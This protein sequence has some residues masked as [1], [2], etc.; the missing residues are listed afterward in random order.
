MI[1]QDTMYIKDIASKS[2]SAL[3]TELSIDM[4][5]Y[6]FCY[7]I[8]SCMHILQSNNNLTLVEIPPFVLFCFTY[9]FHDVYGFCLRLLILY[10]NNYYIDHNAFT[11]R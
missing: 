8:A 5:P 1:V 7:T 9:Q 4:L 10:N 6:Q 3:V 2:A 11:K